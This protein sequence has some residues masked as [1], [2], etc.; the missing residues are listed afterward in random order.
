MK[1]T[2]IAPLAGLAAL[3]LAP[4][5]LGG[6]NFAG[7]PLG[8]GFPE[9]IDLFPID[10]TPPTA[11]GGPL[12]E[13]MPSHTI[14][15][16]PVILGTVVLLETT[17]FPPDPFNHA[18]WSDVVNFLQNAQGQY[19]AEFWSDVE[20]VPLDP[21]NVNLGN[22]FYVLESRT[23]PFT[24]YPVPG[25][26]YHIWSDPV[27]SPASGGALLACLGAAALRRRR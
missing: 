1:L 9:V 3:A 20:G 12:P 15:P 4:A 17:F 13:T 24:I 16:G 19:E 22:L 18:L 7:Q 6:A 25:L 27:P 8:P 11:N 2:I 14:L 5:A 23:D 21:P 26:V 10:Y